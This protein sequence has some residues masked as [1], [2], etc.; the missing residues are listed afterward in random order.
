MLLGE[1]TRYPDRYSPELLEAFS[2]QEHRQLLGIGDALPFDGADVWNA[3]EVSWLDR[4]G[5]P[6]VAAASL[7]IPADSPRLIESKSLKLYLNSLAMSGFASADEVRTTVEKD[8]SEATGSTVGLALAGPGATVAAGLAELPGRCI[9]DARVECRDFDVDARLLSAHA[10]KPL[11]ETLYSHLF[12]SNCPVTGQPDYG[13]IL[14][15]YQGAPIDRDGLLRYLVSYRRHAA[16]HENCIERIFTDL[17]A[18]CAPV[19][20][21]VHGRFTRRGG[22]DINP[23]RSDFERSAENPRLW[24]Q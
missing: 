4:H 5:K 14:V 17:K 10:G 15:R 7:R 9:D 20:L 23:F 13:S 1:K 6:A 18:Q 3:Y 2:R 19:A 11:S 12:R 16:F 8:L 21:T 22:I 24:R